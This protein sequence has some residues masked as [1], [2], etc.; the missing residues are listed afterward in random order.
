MAQQQPKSVDATFY[1]VVTP[2]WSR[3]G[4]DDNGRPILDGAKVERITQNRPTTVKGGAV[5]TRLT[6][7]IDATALL[8][9]QPQAVI[10]ITPGQVEVIDVVAEDP[11]ASA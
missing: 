10:H 11:E 5:V 9:L 1:A 2:E 3:W 7:R 6:L 4:K 8:P